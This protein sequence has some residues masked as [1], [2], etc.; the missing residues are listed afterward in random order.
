MRIQGENDRIIFIK[1]D[2]DRDKWAS[3]QQKMLNVVKWLLP[4]QWTSKGQL[5]Y[6]EGKGQPFSHWLSG[7]PDTE[8][9]WAFLS[10]M[11]DLC[12]DLESHLL[13]EDRLFFQPDWLWWDFESCCIQTIYCP[14]LTQ[15][16]QGGIPVY[17]QRLLRLMFRRA[18]ADNWDREKRDLLFAFARQIASGSRDSA[19]LTAPFTRDVPEQKSEDTSGEKKAGPD[20]GQAQAGT[21]RPAERPIDPEKEKALD[22]LIAAQQEKEEPVRNFFQK[23]RD[24][25]PIAIKD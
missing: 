12:N 3:Y 8:D 23:L 14:W 6:F 13:D 7:R 21:K 16:E 10:K 22:A 25:F 18:V 11:L 1:E 20:N 24:S 5:V 2:R 9:L 4:Y 19:A 15:P 17:F